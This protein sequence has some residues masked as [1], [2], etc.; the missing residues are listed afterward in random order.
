M[1]PGKQKPIASKKRNAD[2][3]FLDANILMYAAGGSHPLRAVCRTTLKVAV[4][5]RVRLVTNSEVLQEILYRYF[6]LDRPHAARTVYKAATSLCDEVYA[7]E[8]RHTARALELLL[9]SQN[10]SPR[11]AIHVATMESMD[12]RRILSTDRDFD[13]I[14]SVERIDPAVFIS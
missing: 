6:S 3:Y 1:V 5:R 2:A 9:E 14:E 10:L 4:D 13:D 8:E 11:D 7:V 12:L